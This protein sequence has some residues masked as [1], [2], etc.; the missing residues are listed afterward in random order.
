VRTNDTQNGDV[1]LDKGS[2][3]PKQHKKRKEKFLLKIL[4]IVQ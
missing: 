4:F 2:K 1:I 3:T